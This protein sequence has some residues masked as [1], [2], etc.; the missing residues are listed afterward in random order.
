[1]TEL[2]QFKAG[3][4]VLVLFQQDCSYNEG[5]DILFL[6][7]GTRLIGAW[8]DEQPAENHTYAVDVAGTVWHFVVPN[9][10][11]SLLEEQVYPQQEQQRIAQESFDQAQ[12]QEREAHL[13]EAQRLYAQAIV[14]LEASG[15][16]PE[17][18]IAD[19]RFKRA[20]ILKEIGVIDDA[21]I[22]LE[23]LAQSYEKV[24]FTF[25]YGGVDR[26]YA[27]L[28]AQALNSVGR[29]ILYHAD[30]ST[31]QMQQKLRRTV[32][33]MLR[34]IQPIARR[35]TTKTEVLLTAAEIFFAM[36]NANEAL[37]LFRQADTIYHDQLETATRTDAVGL[38][39]DRVRKELGQ[40]EKKQRK[41][42]ADRPGSNKRSTGRSRSNR[43]KQY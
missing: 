8:A 12:A 4:L 34:A 28:A 16:Q 14:E 42:G 11:A 21:I 40:P 18:K 13:D 23:R 43:K 1:M 31:E 30:P 24:A 32:D 29:I 36:G 19:A 27:E 25:H 3:D 17:G 5:D 7:R 20:F 15:E 38:H 39:L 26:D 41:R 2:P 10:T 6:P 9:T 35:Y 37:S 22:E 33:R